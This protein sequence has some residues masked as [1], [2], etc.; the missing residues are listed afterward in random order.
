MTIPKRYE[1]LIEEQ[2]QFKIAHEESMEPQILEQV[3]KLV[4]MLQC[5]CGEKCEGT[6]NGMPHCTPGQGCATG[7]GGDG[8]SCCGDDK[9]AGTFHGSSLCAPGQGCN[10]HWDPHSESPEQKIEDH[11]YWAKATDHGKYRMPGEK[12]KSLP[13]TSWEAI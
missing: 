9:A 6:F 12:P 4:Q 2:L 11:D 5:K 13:P 1:E 7:T 3:E 8:C 10:S